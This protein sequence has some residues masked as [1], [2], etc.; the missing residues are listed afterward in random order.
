MDLSRWIEGAEFPATKVDLIDAAE[1][2]EAPQDVIERLQ[3]L[4][5]EQYSSAEELQAE[6]DADD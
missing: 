6:L 4:T 5:E 1:D 2:A 3:A